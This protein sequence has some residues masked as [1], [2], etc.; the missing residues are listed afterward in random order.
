MAV[1]LNNVN[2]LSR[3]KQY[4]W[5]KILWIFFTTF[6]WGLNLKSKSKLLTCMLWYR[7]YA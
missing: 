7:K 4:R 2:I 5:S 3:N 6:I 1:I